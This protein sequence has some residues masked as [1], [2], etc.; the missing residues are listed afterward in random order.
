MFKWY[1]F[2]YWQEFKLDQIRIFC[3]LI[4]FGKWNSHVPLIKEYWM[5]LFYILKK[6][7]VFEESNSN[8]S[9]SDNIL[10]PVI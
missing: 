2:S 4:M 7:K 8:V 5:K 1:L 3:F 6:L 10:C 9:I